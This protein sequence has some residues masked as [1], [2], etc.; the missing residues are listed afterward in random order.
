MRRMHR[1]RRERAI[2]E[3]AIASASSTDE[4]AHAVL[5]AHASGNF[6]RMAPERIVEHVLSVT[7]DVDWPVRL[8]ALQALARRWSNAAR[9][10]LQIVGRPKGALGSYRIRRRTQRGQDSGHV[11]EISALDPL[12]TSCS[13]R[14]FVRSSLG[15]CK[16][17]L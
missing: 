10:E 4:E 5:T 11:V 17:G 1:S 16:H 6:G 7:D 8:A 3:A 9:D 2:D 15:L 14:D 13:C 12:S